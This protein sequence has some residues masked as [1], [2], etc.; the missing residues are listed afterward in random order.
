MEALQNQR[1]GRFQFFICE[2]IYRFAQRPPRAKRSV[3]PFD[4]YSFSL[5]A[6]LAKK[7]DAQF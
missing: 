5:L 1:G 6:R 3:A 4:Q 2:F 7:N